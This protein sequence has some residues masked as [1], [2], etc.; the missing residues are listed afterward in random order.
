MRCSGIDFDRCSSGASSEPLDFRVPFAADAQR[1][2]A[3]WLEATPL[4]ISDL[5]ARRILADDW[6]P[7]PDQGQAHGVCW[8]A[9]SCCHPPMQPNWPTGDGSRCRPGSANG[10]AH[11]S[12]LGAVLRTSVARPVP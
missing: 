3:L 8:D 1:A 2:M 12:T 10:E 11:I 4:H 5:N 9:G 6:D 7:I